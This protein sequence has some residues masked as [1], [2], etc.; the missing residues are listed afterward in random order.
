MIYGD[1]LNFQMWWG[2]L[3]AFMCPWT[4]DHSRL[5]HNRK[6]QVAR[7][8]A[9]EKKEWC[10]SATITTALGFYCEFITF[11]STAATRYKR[12]RASKQSVNV[13][14]SEFDWSGLSVG[15]RSVW[16]SITGSYASTLLLTLLKLLL[17][18]HTMA[19]VLV[20]TLV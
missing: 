9:A 20:S 3:P 1:K 18:T 13:G 5:L 16:Q 4:R 12:R 17:L 10:S 6:L 7:P 15:R 11:K 19:S 2:H 8:S 14:S